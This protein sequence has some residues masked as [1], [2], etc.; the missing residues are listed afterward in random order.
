MVGV[1]EQLERCAASRGS[2]RGPAPLE[3]AILGALVYADLF[4]YP[5][6]LLEIHRYLI[7]VPASL[8]EIRTAIARSKWLT[9]RIVERR[10]LWTLRGREHL[11]ELRSQRAAAA[12]RLWPHALRYGRILAAL[13]YVRMG[14]VTGALAMDNAEDGDD[15]DYLIVT[16]PGRLWLCRAMVIALVRWAAR[17]GIAL[18]PNYFLSERALALEDRNL[19]TAHEL[20]QMIP[21]FGGPIYQHMRAQNAWTARFLPNADGPP[22]SA[23]VVATGGRWIRAG[24][25][26]IGRAPP[27]AWLEAWEMRRKIRKFSTREGGEVRFDPDHCQGH[28]DGHGQRTLAAFAERFHRLCL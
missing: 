19:F 16:A 11:C 25:E 22:W 18:C 3:R 2:P 8:L 13:P 10:G 12:A 20:T 15:I 6:T 26:A 7:A 5:L 9:D 23:E 27:G 24:L 17:H 28:F 4:D 1:G 14:A 21:L